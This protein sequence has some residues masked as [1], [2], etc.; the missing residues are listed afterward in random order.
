[1]AA[2]PVPPSTAS[3]QITYGLTDSSRNPTGTALMTAS[4]DLVS[5]AS[6]T[7]SIETPTTTVVN[8]YFYLTAPSGF[9]IT[10]ITDALEG[11]VLSQWTR[12]GQSWFYGPLSRIRTQGSYSVT[13]QRN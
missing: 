12:S 5:G 1:M 8:Q 10:S 4:V 2:A 11:Q 9:T 6:H 3:A 7:F 13:I